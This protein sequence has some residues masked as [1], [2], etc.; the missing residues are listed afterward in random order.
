DAALLKQGAN[1]IKLIV[2]AGPI[3]NGII[4]DYVRLELDDPNSAQAKLAP[5]NTEPAKN[6]AAVAALP[7]IFIAGDSTAANGIPDA[8]GWGKHLGSFFDPTKIKV[9]N[10]ARG[11]R[12]SRTFITEG[13]WSRLLADVKVGDIVLIQFGH[14]DGAAINS[15]RLARGSLP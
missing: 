11:G 10:Q 3:N 13:H 12:S 1:V 14:N 7:T 8:I 6:G 5:A 2:P 15:E 4:Y 9:V